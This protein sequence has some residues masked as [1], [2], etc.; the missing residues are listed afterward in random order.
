MFERSSAVDELGMEEWEADRPS[1]LAYTILFWTW[2]L[3]ADIVRSRPRRRPA[4][5][6]RGTSL[7]RPAARRTIA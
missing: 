4:S 5:R 3:P 7:R 2:Y 6:A 1:R